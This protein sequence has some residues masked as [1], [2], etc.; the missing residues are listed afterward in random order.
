[1]ENTEKLQENMIIR[2]GALELCIDHEH[3]TISVDRF[4]KLIQAEIKLSLVEQMYKKSESYNLQDRLS[5]L[6]GR[7]PEKGDD[8]A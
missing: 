3:I 6:F 8:N 4:E 5:F 7:L 1:M 2:E